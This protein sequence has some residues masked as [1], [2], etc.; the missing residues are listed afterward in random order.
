MLLTEFKMVQGKLPKKMEGLVVMNLNRETC[1]QL[2]PFN[3]I[4]KRRTAG[5]KKNIAFVAA[6]RDGNMACREFIRMTN[7][8]I[9][10]PVACDAGACFF[11]MQTLKKAS[12][13]MVYRANR[14]K[15]LSLVYEG[16]VGT[17]ERNLDQIFGSD[18]DSD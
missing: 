12:Q 1:K 17:L 2:I 7:M 8:S 18:S 6:S 11:D 9:N 3:S 15:E 5:S 14:N 4:A 13:I 10:V 16:H